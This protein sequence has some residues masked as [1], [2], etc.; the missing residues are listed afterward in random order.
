MIRQLNN[1][2]IMISQNIITLAI[3][4]V[5]T[6]HHMFHTQTLNILL[7]SCLLR[8]VLQCFNPKFK[9][10]HLNLKPFVTIFLKSLFRF[11]LLL[12]VLKIS[13]LSFW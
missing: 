12:N 7:P 1:D 3:T 13:S 4:W 2:L 8:R 9:T 5:L 11:L 10:K 6:M